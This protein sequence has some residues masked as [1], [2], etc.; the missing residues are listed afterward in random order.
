MLARTA[1]LSLSLV[2]P[3][4]A[5]PAA[6]TLL[7][8]NFESYTPGILDKNAAA[9]ANPAPNGTGQPWWGPGTSP[10]FNVV[11]GPQ[12]S[13]SPHSG[14]QMIRGDNTS[15][16]HALLWQNLA[17]R[18]N[19]GAPLPGNLQYDFW[20]YDTNGTT[21]A[22]QFEANSALAFY[23]NAPSNSDYPTTPDPSLSDATPSTIQRLTLGAA[24]YKTNTAGYPQTYNSSRYQ[25][26]ILGYTGGYNSVGWL[27]LPLT[28][29]VGWHHGQ[30]T[31]GPADPTG[32]NAVSYFIDDLTTPL[33]SYATDLP[34]GYNTLEFTAENAAPGYFDDITLLSTP[35]PATLS[36][37]IPSAT[38]L[39]KRRR[40]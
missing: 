23:D 8:D 22:G 35:E 19:A 21:N 38:L 26:R 16:V 37:L 34:N 15:S 6:T 33:F 29:S 4:A 30:I 20:F 12:G 24:N 2:L 1:A 31:V 14:S 7:S 10:N 40:R 17:F 36:L 39:G 5:A 32:N 3:V 11:A 13:I 25:A 18:T 28:R 9:S 27:N